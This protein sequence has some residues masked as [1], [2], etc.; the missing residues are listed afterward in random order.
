MKRVE[1]GDG[2]GR[3]TLVHH[4]DGRYQPPLR[5]DPE[6]G[7]RLV[8]IDVVAFRDD[9]LVGDLSDLQSL[10]RAAEAY[11]PAIP[12]GQE[13]RGTDQEGRGDV[14]DFDLS[15]PAYGQEAP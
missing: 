10:V 11:Q 9:V 13:D 2:P 15:I 3:D 12:Q 5:L 8:G 6:P 1:A 14:S 4:E 7:G